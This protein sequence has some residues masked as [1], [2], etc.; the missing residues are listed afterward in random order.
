M[1]R[2]ALSIAVAAACTASG[3]AIAY[4]PD[5]A[6]ST[7][8]EVRIAGATAPTATLRD[9]IIDNLCDGTKA[10]DYWIH[11]QSKHWQ[12]ACVDD[13]GQNV[14]FRKNDGGS[15]DGTSPVD[16][17]STLVQ[18]FAGGYS[19]ATC[20]ASSAKLTA[21]GT[22][23]TEN[24]DCGTTGVNHVMLVADIGIS[25]IEPSA[26]VGDLAP[27]SN[28]LDPVNTR[29]PF[30]DESNMTVE[31]LAGLAFG[32]VVTDK[33]YRALQ[34]DQFPSGHPL[35]STCNPNPAIGT[36]YNT[37]ASDASTAGAL[38]RNGD[39]EK[40]LPNMASHSIRAILRGDWDSW[41]KLATQNGTSDLLADAAGKTWNDATG[42]DMKVCR[43][44]QGS[45]THARTAITFLQ[46]GCGRGGS[47][48]A[49]PLCTTK[50][51]GA[52]CLNAGVEGGSGSGE[53]TD[54]MN[55][56]AGASK[57]ALGY[58]SVEK[59][60]DLIHPFR[61]VKVDGF[62][63]TLDNMLSGNYANFGEVTMQ[64]RGT[65]TGT[66]V[67]LTYVGAPSNIADVDDA[68]DIMVA[69]MQGPAAAQAL[70]ASSA[71]RHPFGNS[72]WAAR[73]VNGN[74]PYPIVKV[75]G[76]VQ[77]P[78][79]PLTHTDFSGGSVQNTCF[80]PVAPLGSLGD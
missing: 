25:D 41:S 57:W 69:A 34:A 52:A 4:N 65:P 44:V 64:K 76:V 71:F 54:C 74:S 56:A 58:H 75:G 16:N 2:K 17:A 18:F 23:W 79:N 10:I 7:V 40:C 38:H 15:G 24:K 59:N 3:S 47:A 77:N 5:V 26:F 66:A 80:G 11:K 46:T 22:S 32:V 29:V 9:V 48:M 49:Q 68:F 14:L 45:G 62:A 73:P 12:I 67:G 37:P 19:T 8:Y 27:V 6:L 70:N 28:D 13:S 36:A 35:A 78:V 42:G 50:E 72:G 43:R 21:A 60:A 33:L 30:A 1:K 39:T 55:G 20:S 61:F 63:P 53:L 51:F 31:S